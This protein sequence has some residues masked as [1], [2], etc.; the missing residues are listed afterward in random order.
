MTGFYPTILKCPELGPDK[1]LTEQVVLEGGTSDVT[2]MGME[3]EWA[4]DE[5][6][7]GTEWL[8]D[9]D[10]GG[11]GGGGVTLDGHLALLYYRDRE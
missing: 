6:K 10:R 1:Y 9:R 5:P 7:T 4:F 3:R 8:D 2:L 11:A